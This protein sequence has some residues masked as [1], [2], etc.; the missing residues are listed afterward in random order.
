MSGLSIVIPAYNEEANVAGTV[1]EVSDIAGQLSMKYEIMV[2]NDGS[3]DRTA[4]IVRCLAQEIPLLKL[5]EHYPN[6]GYGAA[7]KAGFAAASNELIAFIP[8]DG[9]FLFSEIDRFLERIPTADIVCG[10]RVNRQDNPIRRLNGWGWNALVRLLF[11]CPCRDVDCGF[12]LLRREVV[13][14]VPMPS[15]G[16]MIDTELLAGARARGFRIAEVPVTHLPRVAGEATGAKP[17]VILKA[18]RELLRF[19][20]RLSRETRMA[21]GQTRPRPASCPHPVTGSSESAR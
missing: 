13:E 17:A 16:A 6:R 7:L 1:R 14:Q 15:D 2:V 19:R 12:K 10:Y 5:V 9:Q 21:N 11:G 4:E 20:L 8:A 3:T 18:F